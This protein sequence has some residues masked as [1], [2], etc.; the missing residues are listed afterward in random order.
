MRCVVLRILQGTALALLVSACSGHV[1]RIEKAENGFVYERIFNDM[2]GHVRNEYA[3]WT[4]RQQAHGI[5]H[6]VIDGTCAS[7]CSFV[8]LTSPRSC[9]TKSA[10]LGL[11]PASIGGVME[12]AETRRLTA[13]LVSL[14]PQGLRDWWAANRPSVLGHDL[15]YADLKRIIPER[16]CSS[17]LQA[18]R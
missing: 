12:T 9:Y 1:S 15:V 2:G 13:H 18:A 11:H 16:E 3:A 6:Y 5:T 4:A 7:F 10:R 14:W 8:A 17:Q